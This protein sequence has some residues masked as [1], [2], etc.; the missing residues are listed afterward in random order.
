MKYKFYYD[1]GH[2][3]LEV[4]VE[5]LKQLGIENKISQYSYR[6]GDKVYLEE[7]CDFFVFSKAKGWKSAND[8]KDLI[9]EISDGDES[10]IRTYEGFC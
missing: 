8:W 4:D 5:E 6:N 9:E 1:A 3:W 7:D 10:K 2:G